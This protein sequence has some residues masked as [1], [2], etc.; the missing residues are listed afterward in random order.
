TG[1]SARYRAIEITIIEHAAAATK[2]IAMVVII[3][4]HKPNVPIKKINKPYRKP[5]NIDLKYHP[6]RMI[7]MINN[8]HGN[9]TKISSIALIIFEV[10]IK[11]ASKKLLNVVSKKLTN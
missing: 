10:M 3:S 4:S 5:E 11:M 8:H 1:Q 6:K 2:V 7:K 9:H